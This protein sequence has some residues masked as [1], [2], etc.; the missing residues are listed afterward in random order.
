MVGI[1]GDDPAGLLAA[2]LQGVQ[3]EGDEVGGVG[4]ADDAEDAAFLLQ[5]VT[6]ETVEIERMGGGHLGGHA[7]GSRRAA[8]RGLSRGVCAAC[9]APVTNRCRADREKPAA[10]WR[11]A[12]EFASVA[13]RCQTK[14]D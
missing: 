3:A 5:F 4:H 1:V 7:S 12:A 2:V 14:R 10:R 6:V 9:H 8:L 13:P 11:I